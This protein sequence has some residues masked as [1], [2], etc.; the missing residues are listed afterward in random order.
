LPKSLRGI[1]PY[2]KSRPGVIL[3]VSEPT[4]WCAGMV[5]VPKKNGKV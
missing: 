2:G 3:K 1:K 5:I 4:A